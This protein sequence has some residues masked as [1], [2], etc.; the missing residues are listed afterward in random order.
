MQTFEALIS[1]LVFVSIIAMLQVPHH[2]IDDSL[3]R[4]QLA[5]D[6]WRVFQLRGNLGGFDKLKMNL[7]ADEITRIT[8]LCIEMEEEDVATCI[9]QGS[10]VRI[11]R[12]AIINGQPEAIHMRIGRP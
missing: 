2:E 1:F 6:V 10:V 7:D 8:G 12:L 5:G 11:E 9:P 3:Y 4:L